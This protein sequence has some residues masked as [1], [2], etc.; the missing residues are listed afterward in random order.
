[1]KG[2][3]G[4]LVQP[5]PQAYKE[6]YSN[7]GKKEANSRQSLRPPNTRESQMVRG[8]CKTLSNKS[9]NM[10][11]SSEPRSP[12]TASPEYTNTSENQKAELKSYLMKIIESFKGDINNV[13]KEIQEKCR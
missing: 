5:G 2:S 8:K 13:L 12:I 3:T 1:M 4:G 11:I 9:Q 6:T 7:P 10:W